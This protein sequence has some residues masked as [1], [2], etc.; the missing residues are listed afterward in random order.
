MEYRKNRFYHV[1]K[2]ITFLFL[3]LQ[4]FTGR[5][6]LLAN[7]E[8]ISGENIVTNVTMDEKFESGEGSNDHK[9]S[10]Y[11][12]FTLPDTAQSG[13]TFSIVYDEKLSSIGNDTGI[14]VKSANG[15]VIGT[16]D[17]DAATRTVTVTLN[18]NVTK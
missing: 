10:V 16:M 2:L 18:D 1:H 7:A 4:I 15:I 6:I 11:A 8:D 9:V 13:D 12:E 5:E 14:P 3:F 17:I